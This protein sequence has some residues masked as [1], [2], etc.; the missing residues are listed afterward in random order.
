M[1][2]L[3]WFMGNGKID[4]VDGR[5]TAVEPIPF[6]DVCRGIAKY[7]FV[8]SDLPLIISL[9]VHCSIEQQKKMVEVRSLRS[10]AKKILCEEFGGFLLKN[11]VEGVDLDTLPSPLLLK[12]KILLKVPD[13]T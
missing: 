7:A 8:A 10:C 3:K 2:N 11:K 5:Y 6:R 13:Q 9:E 1:M 4:L 12:N